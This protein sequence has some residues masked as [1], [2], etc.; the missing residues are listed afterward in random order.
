MF[1]TVSKIKE[2]TIKLALCCV[3][4][5]FSEILNCEISLCAKKMVSK[6]ILIYYLLINLPHASS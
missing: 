2:N 1:W 4:E 6:N 3:H 5:H